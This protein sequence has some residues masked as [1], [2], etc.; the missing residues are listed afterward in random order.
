MTEHVKTG[1]EHEDFA[2]YRALGKEKYNLGQYSDSIKDFDEAICLKPDNAEARNGRKKA[3]EKLK[4]SEDA[5]E[6][7]FAEKKSFAQLEL[8]DEHPKLF[9]G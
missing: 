8:F 3:L 9:D 4:Q 7:F 6:N 5:I 2:F 1:Y